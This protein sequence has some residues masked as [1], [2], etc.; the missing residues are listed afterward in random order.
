MRK[1]AFPIIG[2][3]LMA[4]APAIAE[5]GEAKLA[6]ALDGRVA[7]EPVDCLSL[8][9]IRSTRIINDTAILYETAG[10]T[11]YVNRPESGANSLDQWDV[12][13]TD[14][15]SSRLCDVDVVKLYDNGLNI[16]TGFVLLGDFVPYEKPGD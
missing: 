6:E 1:S 14:T 8:R 12:M 11:I 7:G 15:H 10:D 3:V 2:A 9:D 4:A 5:T 13:V 16:Q